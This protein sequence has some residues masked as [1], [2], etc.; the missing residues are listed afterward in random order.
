MS[1][2]KSIP[3]PVIISLQPDGSPQSD[4]DLAA[5][6]GNSLEQ[7]RSIAVEGRELADSRVLQV[8]AF[9][10]T[11]NSRGAGSLSPRT[12]KAYRQDLQQFL[13]WTDKLWAEITPR[14]IAQFKRYLLRQNLQSGQRMLSDATVRRILGTLRNFYGWMVRSGHISSDPTAEVELPRLKQP[15][16]GILEAAILTAAEIAQIH[17]AIAD[18]SLPERNLALVALLLHGLRAGEISALE[19]ADYDGQRLQIRAVKQIRLTKPGKVPGAIDPQANQETDGEINR[20]QWM[21]LTAQGRRDL[22]QYLRWRQDRGEVLVDTSPLLVS[23]SRRNGGKRLGYDGIRKLLKQIAQQTGID[24][25]IYQFRHTFA[26]NLLLKGMEPH[27]A[28]ILTRHRSLQSFQRYLRA[29]DRSQDQSAAEAAF[30]QILDEP[31][32]QNDS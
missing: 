28:M 32:K 9:L 29:A 20:S 17:R 16:A 21:P 30:L 2:R 23:H 10:Q 19:I 26:T 1:R 7:A 8:E 18:S 25:Y 13:N 22:D 6:S 14:H 15:E 27:H 24:L 3:D 4:R 12:Q 31:A 5:T 11:A